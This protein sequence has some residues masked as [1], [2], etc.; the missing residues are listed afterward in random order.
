M[1]AL[2]GGFDKRAVR[3][4]GH[5]EISDLGRRCSPA[6][7]ADV[8]VGRVASANDDVDPPEGSG[9]VSARNEEYDACLICGRRKPKGCGLGGKHPRGLAVHRRSPRRQ[10]HKM[11]AF[12]GSEA[13]CRGR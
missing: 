11:G 7:A 5:G 6:H 10:L 2:R 3:G 4:V 1:A 13:R 8:L 12:A 9:M